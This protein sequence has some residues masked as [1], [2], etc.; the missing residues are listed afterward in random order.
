MDDP[1]AIIGQIR[2]ELEQL[3]IRNGHHDFEH[4]CRH[5]TRAR[6][7]SNILPATG[8]VAAGG[9]QGRDF[10][11]FRT[12]LSEGLSETH[13][14]LALVSDSPLVFACTLQSKG[15]AAKIES[16]VH[17]IVE[18]GIIP[19]G[20]HYFCVIDVPVAKRHEIKERILEECG[21]ELEIY[22]GQAIAE[23][24]AAPDVFWIANRYLRL[25]S[26]VFPAVPIGELEKWYRDSY[27]AWQDSTRTPFSYPDLHELKAGVR[28]A[29]Q[30]SD[31][32]QDL[33]FWIERL[34]EIRRE[35]PFEDIRHS[36]LYEIIVARLQVCQIIQ[37][38]S[39]EN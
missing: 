34:E 38:I 27:T 22:D 20:V 39:K 18:Q 33:P 35:T 30:S 19:T 1:E 17:K 14:F 24:L 8:P 31:A 25:P 29:T 37:H 3:R 36:A 23:L 12:Y 10:E 15:I 2:F 7:C 13:G 26:E 11:T 6:I 21:V 16:D 5:L 32:K 28:H 9:D 4:L